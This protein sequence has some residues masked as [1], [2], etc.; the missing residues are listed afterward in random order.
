VRCRLGEVSQIEF[1]FPHDF[2]AQF[3]PGSIVNH[4]A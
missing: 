2:L 3:R 4:R 1:G